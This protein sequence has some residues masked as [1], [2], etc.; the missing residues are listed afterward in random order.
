MTKHKHNWQYITLHTKQI[1]PRQRV[2][3]VKVSKQCVCG[4][5]YQYKEGRQYKIKVSQSGL[6]THITYGETCPENV[7]VTFN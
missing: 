6:Q 3:S 2:K 1:F 5:Y 4:A 7:V